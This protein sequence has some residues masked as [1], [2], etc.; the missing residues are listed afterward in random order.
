[1]YN[2]CGQVADWNATVTVTV[3]VTVTLTIK[4]EKDKR[5]QLEFLLESNFEVDT[6]V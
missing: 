6:D 1:M 5:F 2:Y 3:T 4:E